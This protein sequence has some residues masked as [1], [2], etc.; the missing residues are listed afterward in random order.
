VLTLQSALNSKY[1]VSEFI[2]LTPQDAYPLDVLPRGLVDILYLDGEKRTVDFPY[3]AKQQGAKLKS[4]DLQAAFRVHLHKN[5]PMT[6]I[7]FHPE[8]RRLPPGVF[9]PFEDAGQ[10]VTPCYWGSHWPLARGQTTDRG[11]S[12]R[13]HVTPG[14]NSVITWAQQRP[15]TLRESQLQTIDSLGRSKRMQIQTWVWLI[16]LTNAED[17]RVLE[18]AKSFGAPPSIEDLAGARLEVESFAP[19]RR[20]VRLI[21]EGSPIAFTLHPEA[22]CV[23]PVFEIRNAPG[24]MLRVL[25]DESPIAPDRFAWDGHTLWINMTKHGP[26]KIRLEFS[27]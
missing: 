11:I 24:K 9:G 14:H 7:Y 10:T 25:I 15:P 6:A 12:N 18:W 4:R 13:I 1:E 21:A 27:E 20:A 16:G 17:S 26:T 23:N 2:I 22:V 8:E 19:E 3:D 5:D